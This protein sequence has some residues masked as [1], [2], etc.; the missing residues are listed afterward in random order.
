PE[1]ELR[2]DPRPVAG[3]AVDLDRAAE[4]LDAVG[5][6][7]ES[8]SS[9]RIGPADAVVANREH[10]R[11]VALPERDVDPRRLRMLGR[12]RQRLGTDVVRRHLDGSGKTCIRRDLEVDG[13]PGTPRERPQGRAE[14]ALRQA[15]RVDPARDLLQ[16]LDGPGEPSG[17]AGEIGA[18]VAP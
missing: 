18:K 7:G 13:N 14:P 8:R 15:R 9:R 17:D 2:R 11:A 12:V 16:I 4:R 6:P 5:E 1:W 3:A 10:E